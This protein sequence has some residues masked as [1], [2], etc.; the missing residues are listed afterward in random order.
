MPVF[1]TEFGWDPFSDGLDH[2]TNT[3]WGQPLREWVESYENMSWA[4]W[5]FDDSWGPR[6]FDSPA[7]GG[8]DE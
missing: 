1:L 5:C 6:L 2:G 8:A 3:G 7:Q 4:A